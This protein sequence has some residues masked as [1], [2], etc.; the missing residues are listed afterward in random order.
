MGGA[1]RNGTSEARYE[2]PPPNLNL[3]LE[4]VCVCVCVRAR[5]R[6]YQRVC[7]FILAAVYT[8]RSVA[9]YAS[10]CC[11]LQGSQIVPPNGLRFSQG[12]S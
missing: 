8:S 5:A 7:E 4:L 6:A 2:Q 3:H 1:L 9:A 12:I 11:Q 10:K